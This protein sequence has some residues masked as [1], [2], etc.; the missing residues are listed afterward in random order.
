MECSDVFK[1]LFNIG[2]N[3]LTLYKILL[4][5]GMRADEIGKVVG[6]NRSTVQRCLKKLIDCGMVRRYKKDIKE[7]GGYY[8][9][10]ESVE[11]EKLKKWIEDCI[12]RWYEEMKK[13][14]K[15]FEK[16]I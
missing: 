5:R 1:C 2:E 8:Y 3:E 11:P 12:E 14:V 6:K 13:I 7:G 16:L 9:V 10:Y 4:E 15:N